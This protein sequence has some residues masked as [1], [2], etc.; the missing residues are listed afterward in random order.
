LD[1]ESDILELREAIL[2]LYPPNYEIGD[3]EWRAWR[4]FIRNAGCVNITP[5]KK[6]ESE[7]IEINYIK[8]NT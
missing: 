7:V 2:D 6:E 5:F 8:K 3:R 4:A 1:Q